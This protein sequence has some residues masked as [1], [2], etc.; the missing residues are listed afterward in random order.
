M[1]IR[2]GRDDPSVE[3][4]P[5]LLEVSDR[6]RKVQ[7]SM[8]RGGGAAKKCCMLC[9]QRVATKVSIYAQAIINID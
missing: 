2:S 9:S 3:K 4:S 5:Q 7:T 6:E 8:N 1:L